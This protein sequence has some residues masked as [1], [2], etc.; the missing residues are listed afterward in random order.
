MP[1]VASRA[2][3]CAF[4]TSRARACER[5]ARRRRCVE[6]RASDDDAWDTT[7]ADATSRRLVF[8]RVASCALAS[9]VASTARA[10]TYERSF[11]ERFETSI[12]S[13]THDYAFEYPDE[14]VEDGVSLNDG[15]LYGVD[16]R[17]KSESGNGQ[18]AVHV[19]PFVG[20]DS[21]KDIGTPEAALERFEELIGAYWEQNGFGQS[22]RAG[23][24]LDTS[25]KTIDG[26]VYYY[27]E[28]VSPHNLISAAVVDGQLYVMNASCASRSWKNAEASL[29]AVVDSFRVPK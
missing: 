11:R 16:E 10:L 23:S 7:R 17:K 12:S 8:T 9:T 14:W 20:A 29:R 1:L 4:V 5:R 15:K 3:S 2:R 18:L 21:I 28:L 27:Y 24:I 19:L 26:V 6:A 13:G 25:I 22:G